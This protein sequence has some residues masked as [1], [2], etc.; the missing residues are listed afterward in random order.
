ML[1]TSSLHHFL[2]PNR[3]FARWRHLTTT[4][5]IHFVSVTAEEIMAFVA[6]KVQPKKKLRGGVEFVHQIPKS[7]S[8]K[9]LR[10]MLRKHVEAKSSRAKL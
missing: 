8:G 10:R 5:R 1:S 9:I 3:T 6:K 7:A 2:T 4:T